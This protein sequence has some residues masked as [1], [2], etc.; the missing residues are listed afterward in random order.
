MA[1]IGIFFGSE[2][3]NT[4]KIAKQIATEFGDLAAKP[5]N[6]NRIEPEQLTEYSYLILGTPTLAEGLLPGLD[7]ECSAESWAEFLPKL[8]GTDLS[9]LKVA[10]YGLG[11]QVNYPS[12]FVDALGELFDAISDC[13]ADLVGFWPNDGYEFEDSAALMED[14]LF[15]GLVLDQDN[16]KAKTEARLQQ[17]LAQVREEFGL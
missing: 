15:V 6:I 14:G 1:Q 13:G 10:L 11:D 7:A 12:C 9:G 3:G 17:W 8:E 4:R 16:Q 2:T 5:L